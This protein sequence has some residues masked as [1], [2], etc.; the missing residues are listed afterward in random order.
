MENTKVIML[1]ANTNDSFKKIKNPIIAGN[2]I[3]R[4]PTP[5]PNTS[6]AYTMAY[7]LAITM[8]PILLAPNTLTKIPVNGIDAA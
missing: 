8:V 1:P 5:L 4:V 3:T 2:D 6:T 7:I